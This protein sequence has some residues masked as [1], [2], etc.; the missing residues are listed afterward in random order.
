VQL[1]KKEFVRGERGAYLVLTVTQ[2][3][4]GGKKRGVGADT[5]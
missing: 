3:L 1:E 2:T 5:S 4:W